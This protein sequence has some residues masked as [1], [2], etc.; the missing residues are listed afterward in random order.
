MKLDINKLEELV[1]KGIVTSVYSTKNAGIQMGLFQIQDMQVDVWHSISL[2]LGYNYSKLCAMDVVCGIHD[3]TSE[4]H[5]SITV[6]FSNLSDALEMLGWDYTF[7][8]E[9]TAK[10]FNQLMLSSNKIKR[11]GG[12]DQSMKSGPVTL[13]EVHDS[14]GIQ[15]NIYGTDI[16]TNQYFNSIEEVSKAVDKN[17]VNNVMTSKKE[18]T[19]DFSR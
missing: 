10:M 8:K 14:R 3:H 18:K 2:Q 17:Y 4:N 5:Y 1:K 11:N 7:S 16:D 6:P 19:E 12:Y 15:Y 13:N 9:D